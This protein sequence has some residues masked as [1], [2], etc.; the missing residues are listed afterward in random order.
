MTTSPPPAAGSPPPYWC[1]ISYRH[2]DNK[3]PGR[4]W[5]TWLHQQIETYEVPEDL[6]GTTNQRG[7][8]IPQ[9]IF[10]VFRDEEELP[11][12]A[13]LGSPIYRAL[14]RSLFLL[15]LCSPQA[16]QSTYVANEI[17]YFKKL[18]RSNSVL[19]DMIEGE[20]NASWDEGKQKAGL[21]PSRECFP[22]PLQFMVDAQ[23]N[24]DRSQRAEPIAADF[25]LPN[26]AQG[27]TSPEAFRQSIDKA[28]PKAKVDAVVDAY[29]QQCEL[30]RLK[31][32]AGIL[33][34][35]LGT[36]TQRDK[37]YQLEKERQRAKTFRKVAT[38]L[39]LLA[40]AAVGASILAYF[41]REEAVVNQ[42][43]AESA[44][45]TA[46]QNQHRAESAEDEAKINLERATDL[47]WEASYTAWNEAERSY[48]AGDPQA[49]LA[50][51]AAGM[52]NAPE[53][54]G[55]FTFASSI[56]GEPNHPLRTLT[57]DNPVANV[58]YTR[59]VDEVIVAELIYSEATRY[60]LWN[61]A[62]VEKTDEVLIP[63]DTEITAE[64][65]TAHPWLEFAP[66]TRKS[67]NAEGDK[68]EEVWSPC[69]MRSLTADHDR[70]SITGE[71]ISW[72]HPWFNFSATPASY[73]LPDSNW[74]TGYA[75]SP[76]GNRVVTAHGYIDSVTEQN[77]GRV[78]L[79]ELRQTPGFS[80]LPIK[81]TPLANLPPEDTGDYRIDGDYML[82]SRENGHDIY[83][84]SSAGT[85]PTPPAAPS[86]P[87][88][89]KPS[90]PFW[91]NTTSPPS[92]M[93]LRI[94]T[95]PGPTAS[96]PATPSST[97]TSPSTRRTRK[98]SSTTS[99][100]ATTAS[101]APPTSKPTARNAG[102]S[103]WAPPRNSSPSSNSPP[104]W[105]NW[106]KSSVVRNRQEPLED[107]SLPI[108][109][110]SA[111]SEICGQSPLPAS[112]SVLSQ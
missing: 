65:K 46:T 102:M 79:W 95:P 84:A 57:F 86:P 32:I 109:K 7:E 64:Q 106:R 59:Q 35:P 50:Y 11:A 82:G 97:S 91:R 5:A 28:V 88:P 94:S 73:A 72:T 34:V 30:A 85:S 99:N 40:V 24:L 60:S 52:R 27:W 112:P 13:D 39:G 23:G 16:V 18:G 104:P 29:R 96:T 78:Q 71:G 107:R 93:A 6:V 111:I 2:A 4:Q 62:T 21:H 8:L 20:P 58:A 43:R 61:I 70:I 105:R 22:D 49:A 38:A 14:D 17:A 1:F 55:L 56:L 89:S 90:T 48:R 31:I 98:S 77:R 45:I 15:V 42:R 9:R 44:T 83:K 69:S 63:T 92:G 108:S 47:L 103:K 12:D 76:D 54:T 110:I 67:N 75:W 87:M 37:A 26:G 74:T 25:R 3:Q 36:L 81:T 19:A 41:K 101:P 10:P 100:S 33:G 66:P 53:N 51:L 80:L 68:L